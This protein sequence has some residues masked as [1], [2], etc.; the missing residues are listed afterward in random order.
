MAVMAT[1][2][3]WFFFSFTSKEQRILEVTYEEKTK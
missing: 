1:S 3:G 2:W